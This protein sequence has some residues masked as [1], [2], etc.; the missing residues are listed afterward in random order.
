MT[1]QDQRLIEAS[2]HY[3][4]L[5]DSDQPLSIPD[6]VATADPALRNELPN[7]LELMLATGAGDEPMTL[8]QDERAMAERAAARTYDRM[9]ARTSTPRP[10]TI[11]EARTAQRLSLGALARQL[12]LPPDLLARIERGGI[13]AA[14]IPARLVVNLAAALGQAEADVRALLTARALA[15]PTRLSAADGT[16][17]RPESVV[18]FEEAL[19]VSAASAAQR[20]EWA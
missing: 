15:T 16:V 4:A 10:R 18:S 2:M 14:T 13:L 3:L 12:N 8:T 9:L 7:Y 5:L 20:K 1:D 17:T 19:Q 11:S 6:F